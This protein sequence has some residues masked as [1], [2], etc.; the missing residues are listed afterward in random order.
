M[1]RSDLHPEF[2]LIHLASYQWKV[3]SISRGIPWILIAIS[4]LLVVRETG[5]DC[6]ELLHENPRRRG[7]TRR[8]KEVTASKHFLELGGM[9]TNRRRIKKNGNVLLFF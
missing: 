7:R 6:C 5:S 1:D 2:C 3:F 9:F 4:F 8:K